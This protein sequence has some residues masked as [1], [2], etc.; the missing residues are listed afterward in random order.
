M[1]YVGRASPYCW[2]AM[3]L[4]RRKG[5]A[6]EVVEVSSD[7]EL[8]VPPART[9]GRRAVPQVFIDGRLVGGFEVMKALDRATS[10][11]WY[12]AP[13]RRRLIT[14]RPRLLSPL[15]DS[16][17][18]SIQGCVVRITTPHMTVLKH[19]HA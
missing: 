9:T 5:N 17:D 7:D 13:S 1:I 15:V 14:E 11:A 3:R 8:P 18:L 4:L 2:R 10:T 12:G 6:L 19:R 16:R